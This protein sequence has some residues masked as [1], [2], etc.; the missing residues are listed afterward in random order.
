MTTL[1]I[2]VRENLIQRSYTCKKSSTADNTKERVLTAYMNMNMNIIN[3]FAIS[4]I[5]QLYEKQECKL[6][7]ALKYLQKNN[8]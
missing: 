3:S 4:I 5:N 8:L 6:E 7:Y 1:Q 2:T